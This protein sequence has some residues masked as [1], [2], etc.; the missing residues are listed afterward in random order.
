MEKLTQQFSLLAKVLWTLARI[1]GLVR[2]VD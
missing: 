1:K 2:T